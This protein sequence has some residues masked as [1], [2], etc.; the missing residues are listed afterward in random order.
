[1]EGLRMRKIIIKEIDWDKHIALNKIE[2][3]VKELTEFM[4]KELTEFMVKELTEFM[5]K[6]LT[7]IKNPNPRTRS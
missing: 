7:L 4:V 1:M 6:E 2:F 5:V 3:M